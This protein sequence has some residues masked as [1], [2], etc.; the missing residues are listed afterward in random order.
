MPPRLLM[1][2]RLDAPLQPR[3]KLL[4]ELHQLALQITQQPGIH[5]RP[6]ERPRP[7]SPP[8]QRV[9]Y[10]SAQDHQPNEV[11]KRTRLH[12]FLVG[13]GVGGARR[14]GVHVLVGGERDLDD[15][16]GDG[17]GAASG[18]GDDAVLREGN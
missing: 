6:N 1:L 11:G 2:E 5:R 12:G 14:V 13:R 10:A 16:L 17:D 4:V 7:P 18:E 15:F 9:R 8:I 3:G